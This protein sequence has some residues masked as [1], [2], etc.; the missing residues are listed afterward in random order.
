MSICTSCCV[1]AA[2]AA[3][4]YRE[5][6]FFKELHAICKCEIS[7]IAHMTINGYI[8]IPLIHVSTSYLLCVVLLLACSSEMYNLDSL[9]ALAFM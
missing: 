9:V 7:S 5:R 1:E 2:A 6:G 3:A 8:F 4:S